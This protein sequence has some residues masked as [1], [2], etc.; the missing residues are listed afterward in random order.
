MLVG[1]VAATLL[2]LVI[3][4]PLAVGC[5][6]FLAEVAPPHIRNITRPGLRCWRRLSCWQ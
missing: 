2:A 6:I 1:S 3:A 5:A 4:V